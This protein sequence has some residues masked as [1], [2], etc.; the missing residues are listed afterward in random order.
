MNLTP[1]MIQQVL[2]KHVCC[3]SPRPTAVKI[4]VEWLVTHGMVTP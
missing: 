4:K 2:C 3:V 1:W